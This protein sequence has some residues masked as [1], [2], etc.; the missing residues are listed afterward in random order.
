MIKKILLSASD[1]GLIPYVRPNMTSDN[2]GGITLTYS[3]YYEGYPG[4][5]TMD[6]DSNSS[7]ITAWN[8]TTGWLNA[9]FDK[10]L[11]LDSDS[12][13]VLTVDVPNNGRPAQTAIYTDSSRTKQ[14][15]ITQVFPNYQGATLS[16]TPSQP[17]ITN[18]L[19]FDIQSS[20]AYYGGFSNI[21][22]NNV[23]QII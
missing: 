6:G 2:S 11:Y 19:F 15:G 18:N 20:Y 14:I 9:A 13:L 22:F 5:Q 1:G 21:Q 8:Y 7:W 4:Y 17:I 16:F 3:S 12:N 23:K 10:Y